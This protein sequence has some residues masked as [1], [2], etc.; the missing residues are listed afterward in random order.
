MK[1]TKKKAKS[2]L[3][4]QNKV[5]FFFKNKILIV[6]MS[7]FLS[8]A[9]LFGY[10]QH[11]IYTSIASFWIRNSFQ[12][13]TRTLKS[14]IDLKIFYPLT[15][16]HSL[17]L[18]MIADQLKSAV[19]HEG[20]D[21]LGKFAKIA[22]N[23]GFLAKI[24][25]KKVGFK[26]YMVQLTPKEPYLCMQMDVTRFVTEKG[27]IYGHAT[28]RN[29]CPNYI[30]NGVFDAKEVSNIQI[31]SDRSFVVTQE[32]SV[33][34]L[35]SIEL[36]KNLEATSF[37]T[38]NELIF[39]KSRGFTAYLTTPPVELVLGRAPFQIKLSRLSKIKLKNGDIN[40][41]KVELDYK[42]KAFIKYAKPSS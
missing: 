14:E 12:S 17:G 38:R 6:I 40:I 21:S 25:S 2:V 39:D 1:P 13:H 31:N 37:K 27:Q 11:K 18:A 22:L 41:E 32:K 8:V 30:V 5:D 42:E 29:Q 26:K 4:S 16:P 3:Y 15:S 20:I 9:L 24:S 34:I 35:E 23:Y 10:F 36:T 19:N 7:G 28:D 33:I